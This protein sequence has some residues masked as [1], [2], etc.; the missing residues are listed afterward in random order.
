MTRLTWGSVPV[1]DR[2][3]NLMVYMYLPEGEYSLT[4]GRAGRRLGGL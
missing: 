1:S 3:R 2:D 4:Q